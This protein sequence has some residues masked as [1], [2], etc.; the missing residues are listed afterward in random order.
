MEL[1]IDARRLDRLQKKLGPDVILPPVSRLIHEASRVASREAV[2]RAPSLLASAIDPVR[3]SDLSAKVVAAHPGARAM[4]G[5]RKPLAAGGRFPP[6]DAFAHVTSSEG[7]QF[8][9]ARAVARRGTKGRFFMKKAKSA[10]TRSLPQLATR[11]AAELE[12]GWAGA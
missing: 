4:E 6:P 12:A 9:I 1:R 3:V 2:S 8:A 11:V 5:G 10:A 7:A